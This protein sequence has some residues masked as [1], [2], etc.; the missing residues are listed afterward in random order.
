MGERIFF[1]GFGGDQLA[2]R[3]DLPAGEPRAYALFAHCFTCSKDVASAY[4]ISMGLVDQGIG[5]LR[6]DFT[7]LGSSEGEFA[8]TNF[9]SNVEDL[10]R[11]AAML[12]G[13]YQPPRILIGHSLG[14]AAVLAAAAQV[15]E[16]KAVATIGA[17]FDPAHVTHL[18]DT[19]TLASLE[20][21]GD[22]AVQI[23]GRPFRIRRQLLL[24]VN[25]Q[26]LGEAI[27]N[28]HKALLVL[29]APRD[30]V[31]DIDNARQIFE[32]ARH[33]KSFVSLD[34]ADHLLT[35]PADSAYV[36]TVLAAWASR[37]IGP[38]VPSAFGPAAGEGVVVVRESGQGRLAQ[39]IRAGRHTLVADEPSGVGDDTGP[40]PY[41]LLLG[42]LGACTSMTL[43]LY[44]DRKGWPLDRVSV[45]LSH[46][47]CHADDG[48]DCEAKPC[49]IDGFERT[50]D[51][52]GPLSEEQRRQL[53]AIAERCPV[54]R[55]LMGD[56]EILTRLVGDELTSSSTR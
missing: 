2:A 22:V 42:A 14:G 5:V 13:R 51:L 30:E 41:D 37:Y 35:R 25:A 26:H 45:Q 53:V 32:T 1:E 27:Q 44:A 4:R 33:P 43:R 34:D 49:L 46:D 31:V 3:L 54:H 29:H 24:D 9:S 50:L 10:L 19:E 39:S 16:A 21:D 38:P 52:D 36:A 7:G 23:A 15:P 12:R 18:L 20:R 8:N 48:R 47:R 11:A 40:T 56:K 55:T 6:F 17:P 28:L